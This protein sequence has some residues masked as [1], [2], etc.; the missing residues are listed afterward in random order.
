M[1]ESR[2]HLETIVTRSGCEA[3]V[4]RALYSIKVILRDADNTFAIF[5]N[6]PSQYFY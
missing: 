4:T 1:A 6:E 3:T 2:E 5:T